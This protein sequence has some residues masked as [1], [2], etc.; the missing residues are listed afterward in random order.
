V[1]VR[2]GEFLVRTKFADAASV[3]FRRNYPHYGDS[4]RFTHKCGKIENSLLVVFPRHIRFTSQQQQVTMAE[5]AKESFIEVGEGKGVESAHPASAGMVAEDTVGKAEGEQEGLISVIPGPVAGPVLN[6]VS[7]NPGD[8]SQ[9]SGHTGVYE[10]N[11]NELS[12]LDHRWALVRDYFFA[13]CTVPEDQMLP[14]YHRSWYERAKNGNPKPYAD[15]NFELTNKIL[16]SGRMACRRFFRMMGMRPNRTTQMREWYPNNGK[17]QRCTG[18]SRTITAAREVVSNILNEN[19]N[20]ASQRGDFYYP[21]GGYREWHSNQY[22][23]HG[24]RLYIV[25]TVPSGCASFQYVD[26]HTKTRHQCVD[27]DGCMRLFRIGS[28]E[29]LLW[30]SII[31]DGQRWSLGFILNE[32]SAA[33][34]TRIHKQLQK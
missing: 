4:F 31:S 34:L 5:E 14:R 24:W 1:C 18:Y 22:D 16:S 10:F 27:F 23:P 9:G 6:R 7:V 33:K 2:A 11:I 8:P 19:L 25:H 13:S 17:F 29:D 12:E 26:P 28:G 30:H 32:E 15:S 3:H 20:V 21:N